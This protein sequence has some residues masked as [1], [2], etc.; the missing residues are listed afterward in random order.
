MRAL[1]QGLPVGDS[2]ERYLAVEGSGSDPRVVRATIQWI[3]D[4]FAAAA[5]REH[6]PGTARLVLIDVATIPDVQAQP[7]SLEAFAAERGLEDF[8][9]AEQLEAYEAE[10]GRASQRRSRR[11]RL[12]DKQL[13]AL[14]WLE[15]LIAQPPRLGD[16][17][18][19]WLHPALAE[20]LH[21]AEIFT[22][23]QLMDRI[24]GLGRRWTASIPGLGVA[25]GERILN[26]LAS[27]EETLQRRVGAHVALPRR[28]LFAHELQRVVA[29][30]TDIRPLEKFIVPAELDGRQGAYRRPQ[31]QC[32]MGARNDYEALLAWLKSRHGPSPARQASA[33]ARRRGRD[34]NAGVEG[35]LEWLECLSHTQRSYRKEAERFL[36]WAVVHKRKPLSSMTTEDCA[37]YR[38]F[39]SD[40]QPRSRWCAPRNRERWSP[41]WRP[42]EGPL[43][44]AAQRQAVTILKSLYAFW[45]D[46]NYVMG[47]PWAGVSV[48]KS[49]QPRINA[50]RSFTTGQWAFIGEQ[51]A[52]LQDRS[53]ALRLKFA[54]T[55]L[56]ASGLRL[57]EAV[58]AKV[59]DLQ[60]VEYP[61]DED[62]GEPVQ[63]W[64]LHVVGKGDKP[65]E[66]PLPI[67]VVEQLRAYLESRGLERAI[68]SSANRGTFV[69]GKASDAPQ[70]AAGLWSGQP[71]DPKEGIAANT[72]YDQLKRF[73]GECADVLERRGDGKVAQRFRRASTHWL[74]HTHASHAI[75]R[76]VRIEEAQQI[77]GH[78]SLA[79][80]TVYVTTEQKRRM[81]AIERFWGKR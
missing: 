70:R 69:L 26:W 79:T 78:A 20:R 54:L 18:A 74:R 42:F 30:A 19:A 41:L 77:L 45:V 17:V 65:R 52:L 53:T 36:L 51:L 3:R 62:D 8:S 23:A 25:K 46:M 68:E 44:Q 16:G 31:A 81:K 22:L 63:G 37:E 75:A 29:P 50:G 76:G 13:A 40:P 24:D 6:R 14:R 43:S 47:N 9:H 48:P 15:D 32:L 72:L 61:P 60:W 56:Y 80:T 11:A 10:F 49:A 64:L 28:K 59:D 34:A 66:V 35:P 2:F 38:T 39:L 55:F 12:A 27:H 4:E 57:S 5:R 67:D 71:I 7:P 58:A 33:K 73:F 21:A 1:V